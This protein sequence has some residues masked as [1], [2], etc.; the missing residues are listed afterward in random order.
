MKAFVNDYNNGTNSIRVEVIAGTTSAITGSWSGSRVNVDKAT[1]AKILSQGKAMMIG[2]YQ[3]LVIEKDASNVY[4][5]YLGGGVNENKDTAE[6]NYARTYDLT[7]GEVTLA[8]YVTGAKSNP[9]D[10]KTWFYVSYNYG[11]LEL[12]EDGQAWGEIVNNK[13]YKKGDFENE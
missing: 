7:K 6:F 1:L 4:A 10:A 12:A 8:D 5:L 2:T 11:T 9:T 3:A 13:G